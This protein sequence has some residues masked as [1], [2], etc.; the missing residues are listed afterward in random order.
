MF[1]KQPRGT[2]LSALE[3]DNEHNLPVST[4]LKMLKVSFVK[5]FEELEHTKDVGW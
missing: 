3:K 2:L 4:K 1:R 5:T